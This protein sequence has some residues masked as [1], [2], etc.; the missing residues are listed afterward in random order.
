M[1]YFWEGA[2]TKIPEKIKS[3]E[4]VSGAWQCHEHKMSP[5]TDTLF[6]KKKKKKEMAHE[7][8]KRSF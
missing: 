5:T 7:S 1:N 3:V 2:A 6:A 8:P 4:F